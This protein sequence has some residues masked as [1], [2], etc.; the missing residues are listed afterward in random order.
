[1]HRIASTTAV[2][3]MAPGNPAVAVVD[4]GETLVIETMD[5]FSN[6][7]QSEDQLFSSIGWECVN[8]ATGPIAI[9]GAEPGDTLKVE[10]VDIVTA[11][12]GTMTTH[13]DYGALPGTTVERTRRIPV[14]DGQVVFNDTISF[15]TNVM[16][17]VIGTAPA[18]E[19][20]PTGSP[21]DHGGNMDT[22]KITTGS[23]LYLP[24]NVP[25]ANLAVGD[26][27]A[28]MGD[29]EV[30]VSGL[31]IAA[32]VTLRVDVIKGRPYPLPFLVTG[33]QVIAIASRTTLDEAVTEATRMMCDFLVESTGMDA[34]ES[35]MLL[36]LTGDLAVSQIVDPLRTA[37]MELPRSILES[38]G[39]ELM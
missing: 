30:S 20:V 17:G 6:T 3:T 35:L 32:E 8:P 39:V 34:T 4:P 19:D 7:I 12:V 23:T 15:P 37:R 13:P 28:A 9:R 11:A 36:S 18:D 27:H 16:I 5:C 2:L 38:Y 22:K 29:G 24:V 21:K 1:M 10:V 26:V 14:V 33:D 31:E 25:G